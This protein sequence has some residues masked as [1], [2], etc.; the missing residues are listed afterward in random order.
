MQ[1]N[2]EQNLGNGDNKL[3][4]RGV[5]RCAGGFVAWVI[6]SGFATGQEVLQFYTS[7]GMASYAIILIDL[8]G[9][10]LVGTILLTGGRKHAD[11][12]GFDQFCFYCGRKLG[13]FYSWLI[14]IMLVAVMAVLISGAGATLSEYYGVNHYVGAAIMAVMVLISYFIGF[15]RLVSVLSFIGPSIIA[16]CLLVGL[17]TVFRDMGNFGQ[18]ASYEAGLAEM[19]PS[20]HWLISAIL[21]ISYNFLCG[22]V[23]YT[24]LG[25]TCSS[26]REA[27]VGAV[28]GAVLLMAVITVINTAILL[29]GGDT[30][31]LAIPNLF[32]A[33]KISWLLGA[34]FSVFLILGIFSA[35]SAMMWTVCTK[36]SLKDPKKDR[37][38][39]V[40]I[41]AGI[42]LLGLLSFSDLIG[43]FYP[44]IGYCGLVYLACVARKCAQER[45]L[46]GR[47]RG[48]L[49]DEARE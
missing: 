45:G 17:L 6:G 39:A 48:E 32:L 27:R 20:G 33:R 10:L 44:V 25:K 43:A 31:A 2:L 15:Q 38:L 9:F 34:V 4:I 36:F 26:V 16:F 46:Y 21:Y 12:E 29:N 47:A 23:Y 49:R 30:A 24:E 13:T 1:A 3:N 14:A 11:E 7:Y 22:S 41:A 42:F 37:F 40:G 18:I 28:V 5:M 35:C 19:Q 8:A